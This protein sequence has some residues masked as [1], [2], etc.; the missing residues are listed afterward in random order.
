MLTD[1]QLALKQERK[2][3][4][5]LAVLSDVVLVFLRNLDK[6]MEGPSTVER[7]RKVALLASFL[8]RENDRVRY[9][10]LKVDYRTDDKKKAYGKALIKLGLK[11]ET[12]HDKGEKAGRD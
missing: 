5:S 1:E 4:K 11:K 8:E 2:D 7:G 6:V 3:Q 12:A 9:T 10:N